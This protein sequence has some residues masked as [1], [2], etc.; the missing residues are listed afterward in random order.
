MNARCRC[1][2]ACGDD[3]PEPLLFAG[4]LRCQDC[5]DSDEPLDP[6]LCMGMRVEDLEAA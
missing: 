4:S 3:L 2:L 5:R 1:C 6:E